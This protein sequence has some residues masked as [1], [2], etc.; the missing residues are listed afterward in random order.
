MDEEETFSEF[1]TE[2]CNIVNQSCG[3]GEKISKTKIIEKI[4]RLLPQRFDPK[5]TVIEESKNLKLLKRDDLVGSHLT[6][7]SR[8]WPNRKENLAMKDSKEIKSDSS[9][10]N[11]SDVECVSL[12]TRNF[13]KFLKTSKNFSRNAHMKGGYHSDRSESKS[14]SHGKNVREMEERKNKGVQCYECFGFGHVKPD[15]GNV[16]YSEESAINVSLSNESE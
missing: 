12:L 8:R 3:L 10:G 15:C 16:K 9:K 11:V 14:D 5:V 7:E 13:H 1:Y 2:L 6:Y 4:L